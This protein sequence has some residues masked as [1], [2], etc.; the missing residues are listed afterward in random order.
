MNRLHQFSH[1]VEPSLR[2]AFGYDNA[3]RLTSVTDATHGNESYSFDDVGNRLTSHLA[4]SYGYQT[5]QFN[6][7]ISATTPT[8]TVTYGFDAKDTTDGGISRTKT[9]TIP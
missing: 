1:I 8:Q 5:G 4:S 6:R 3:D 2:G 9:R 7:L